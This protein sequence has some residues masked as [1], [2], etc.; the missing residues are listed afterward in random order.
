MLVWTNH[1]W[2]HWIL[3]LEDRAYE[4]INIKYFNLHLLLCL[5]VLILFLSLRYQLSTGNVLLHLWPGTRHRY[6]LFNSQELRHIM[7]FF[8]WLPANQCMFP[9]NIHPTPRRVWILE[10]P[11]GRGVSKATFFRESKNHN[12]SFQWEGRGGESTN[13]I[14]L[15]VGIF[16]ET[17][18]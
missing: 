5:H 1:L 11:R 17:T 7:F 2:E 13:Q 16:S 4:L 3:C 8:L 14:T 6:L 9:E 15:G 12:W 10:I 18:Q